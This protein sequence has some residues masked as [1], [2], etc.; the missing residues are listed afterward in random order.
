VALACL[1]FKLPLDLLGNLAVGWAY[2]LYRVVPEVRVSTSGVVTAV[3]CLAAL[4]AGLHLFL[5][6]LSREVQRRRAV[7]G[8]AVRPWPI[9]WTA[10]LLTLVVLLFVAGTAA[11]GIT[12]Q[13]GWLVTAPEP[14]VSEGGAGE[15]VTSRYKLRQLALAMIHYS[16]AKKSLSPA[17]YDPDGKPLLSWRVRILP[18]LEEDDLYNEFRLDEPWDSPH[19]LRLLPRMPTLYAFPQRN[20]KKT[21]LTHYQ[22]FV[23]GGAAFEETRGMRLPEDFKDGMN[24]TILIAEATEPVP[25]TKPQDL[26]YDPDLPLPKLGVLPGAR[27]NVVLADASIRVLEPE[28]SEETHRAAITRAGSDELGPDW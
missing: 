28:V 17:I 3:V 12:H 22:V 21:Y 23:G 16:E 5:R 9:R 27:V 6:W 15:R 26:P 20:G 18:Y 4:T 24:R 11:V 13:T 10:T 14:L 1:G 8:G 19:N 25:W 2:Y 7:A